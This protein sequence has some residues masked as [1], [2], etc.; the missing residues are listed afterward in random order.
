[1]VTLLYHARS[2][3]AICRRIA[4]VSG[5]K[6]QAVCDKDVDIPE[7]HAG[8][9]VR[10]DSRVEMDAD[11]T[12]NSAKVVR[13]SRN[14]RY[15]RLVLALAGLAPATWIKRRDCQFPC[16]VRPKRHYGGHNFFLCN[17]RA[18]LDAAVRRCG[19]GRWYASAFIKK[20]EEFRV[21]ILNGK[22]FKVIRRYR[23]DGD[24]AKPWNFHNGGLSKRI[25]QV[26][27]PEGLADMAVAVA[28]RLGLQLCAVDVIAEGEKLYALEANTAPGL[29]RPKTIKRFAELLG[30]LA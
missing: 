28:T 21:F 15:S 9:L 10:W 26:N 8:S 13:L 4:A 29:D 19:K 24:P 18:E 7:K 3:G 5:G 2:N 14:K 12:I 6:I 23:A 25:K 20:T 1:M 17:N 22:V 11:K 16:V 30:E 27:W